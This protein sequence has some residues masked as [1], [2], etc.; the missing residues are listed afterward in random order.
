MGWRFDLD[1]ANFVA[2]LASES[3]VGPPRAEAESLRQFIWSLST[4]EGRSGVAAKAAYDRGDAA[5]RHKL[6]SSDPD[7]VRDI[8]R[9]A[10]MSY[11]AFQHET[12]IRPQDT[13]LEPAIVERI[14]EPLRPSFSGYWLY[15][16]IVRTGTIYPSAEEDEFFQEVAVFSQHRGLALMP[17]GPAGLRNILDPFP[18][19]QELARTPLDPPAAVFWTAHGATCALPLAEARVFFRTVLLDCLPAGPQAVDAALRQRQAETDTRRFLHMS[20]LHF[21]DPESDKTRRYV[22]SHLA[23]LLDGIDR[24]V[25]TGDL[26]NSPRPELR[27]QFLDFCANVRRMTPKDL[28]VIPG[29]HDVRKRGILGQ[30]YE[31]VVDIGWQPI[32]VDD[33]LECVF[34]CFNSVEEGNLARGRVTNE[35]CMRMGASFDEECD[36]RNRQ[37]QKDIRQYTRIALV[38]HHPFA[39]DTAE[40]AYYEPFLRR[41]TGNQDSFTRFEEADR[42]VTWCAERGV[43][44]ILHGH[45]HVPHHVQASVSVNGAD[46]TMMVVGCGSTTGAEGSPL[47]YDVVS[48]NPKSGRWS[49]SFHEDASR[50]GAGF[51]MKEL[52]IDTRVARAAW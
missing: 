12:G 36:L 23:G 26:F 19:L 9:A 20:D 29:N 6:I 32:V 31:F 37:K 51:R 7:W 5:A 15:C 41:I 14:L 47:C 17:D 25:V 28:I 43:S 4:D 49:V 22:T 38:H 34:F 40:V 52:T 1:H 44:L 24:V 3:R 10:E 27:N 30:T 48:L 2:Y 50:A 11:R 42:F 21:G 33:D 16:L 13:V 39:Y 35:Q 45:K 46:R 18:A 8:R